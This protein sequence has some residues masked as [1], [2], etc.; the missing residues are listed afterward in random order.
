ME[1]VSKLYFKNV[2]AGIKELKKQILI[3]NADEKMAV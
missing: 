1:D 3:R 2:K